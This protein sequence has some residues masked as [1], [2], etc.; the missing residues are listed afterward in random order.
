MKSNLGNQVSPHLYTSFYMLVDMT[1]PTIFQCPDEVRW[2]VE[3]GTT[4]AIVTYDEPLATDNSNAPMLLLSQTC[5]SG[6]TFPVGESA[7]VYVFADPDGNTATCT[8]YI[9]ITIGK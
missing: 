6:D 9:V 4:T 7:C 1:P 8:F 5:R 2:V 3:L